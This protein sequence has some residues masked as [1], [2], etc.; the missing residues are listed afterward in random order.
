MMEIKGKKL[1]NS[2]ASILELII[3]VAIMVIMISGITIGFS[4]VTN[5]YAK[6]AAST[7]RDVLET[8]R[9]KAMTIAADEWK[10][11]ISKSTDG[12]YIYKIIKT[13]TVQKDD[14][15]TEVKSEVIEQEVLGGDLSIAFIDVGSDT[16]NIEITTDKSI[17]IVFKPGIGSV[18]KVYVSG[19]NIEDITGR[20]LGEMAKLTISRGS[21]SKT[22]ELYYTTGKCESVD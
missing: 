22:I 7:M 2:G 5:S 3:A 20:T 17:S 1:N 11:D 13:T 14:G 9:T 18:E 12:D 8:T 10:L 6:R 16:S 15:S 21:Y 4:V 19:T